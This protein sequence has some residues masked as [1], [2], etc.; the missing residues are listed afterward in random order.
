MKLLILCLDGLGEESLRGMRLNRLASLINQGQRANPIPDNVVSRGW[1]EIYSGVSAYESGGFFQIPVMSNGKIIPTQKTGADVVADHLGVHSL[2]WGRLHALG[3]RVGIFGLPTVSKPQPGCE[4]TFPATGAGLFNL[5]SEASGIYPPELS[6]LAIYSMPNHGLRIGRGAFLPK[7]LHHLE[8]WLRD[9]VSQYFFTL[10]HTLRR[11]NVDALI[12]GSRFTDIFYKF[13][14]V[15]SEE[16]ADSSDL[17]LKKMLL[18]TADDFDYELEKF[19][20][21]VSPRDLYIVSDHGISSL[22]YN[23]SINELL[24]KIGFINYPSLLSRSKRFLVKR[25]KAKI[26]KVASIYFPTYDLNSSK[27]FSIGYTDVIYI[28]DGRFTGPVMD[29]GQRFSQAQRLAEELTDYVSKNDLK[30]FIAFQPLYNSG[31]TMPVSTTATP[32]ALPDIRCVLAEGCFNSGQT[33][34]NVA[35]IN[36][37][38]GAR[39]MFE[40]GFFAQHS[41]TKSDD[42]IAAYVGSSQYPFNPHRLTDLYEAIL[43]VAKD[44]QGK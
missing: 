9:H 10:R 1:P 23:I 22:K 41:G 20:K 6:R 39:R 43:A 29:P 31:K 21:D 40:K 28:N 26:K 27:A 3:Y 19:L 13:R 34:G 38:Y 17:S 25:V 33:Y 4:F 14:H 11:I 42:A 8:G 32:I 24:R 16:M 36:Q 12:L 44:N 37:P 7:N 30:Q 35:E 18:E 2:L 15:L 5:S